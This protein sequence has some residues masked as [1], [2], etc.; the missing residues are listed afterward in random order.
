MGQ[1]IHTQPRSSANR[2]NE[3]EWSLNLEA[4]EEKAVIYTY[5]L[6]VVNY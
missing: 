2:L 6:H 5:E 1:Y 3:V 4:G